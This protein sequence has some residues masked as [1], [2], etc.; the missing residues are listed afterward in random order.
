M[1]T[2][3]ETTVKVSKWLIGEVEKFVKRSKRNLSEF[4]SK[5]TLVDIAIIKFLEEKGVKL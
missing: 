5:R 4:P 2:N 3:K 1:V